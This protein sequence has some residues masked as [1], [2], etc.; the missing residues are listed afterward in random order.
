MIQRL[1]SSRFLLNYPKIG[2]IDNEIRGQAENCPLVAIKI[3]PW[4]LYLS[5][6]SMILAVRDG[7]FLLFYNH[8]KH[9]RHERGRRREF[10]WGGR[11][12]FV[13]FV[14]IVVFHSPRIHLAN[15]L[16]A[17]FGQLP[18]LTSRPSFIRVALK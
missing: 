3:A 7:S 16:I 1:R 11:R 9:E 15:R 18:K 12:I 2:L 14:F 17:T 8:E 10:L 13:W 4:G 6:E 5:C